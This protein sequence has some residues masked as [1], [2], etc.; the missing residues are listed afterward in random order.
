MPLL[1]RA[2]EAVRFDAADPSRTPEVQIWADIRPRDMSWGY[3]ICPLAES[4][5]RQHVQHNDW[6]VRHRDGRLEVMDQ[7]GFDHLRG[8]A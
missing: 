2:F 3:V 4:P 6:I 8:R 1:I 5:T 7:A